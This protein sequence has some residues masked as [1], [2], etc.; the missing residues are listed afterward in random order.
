MC[1]IWG[2]K[3]AILDGEWEVDS[4]VVCPNDF[5]AGIVVC[6]ENVPIM[7]FIGLKDKNNREIYEGDII[8]GERSGL[9]CL[10]VVKYVGCSFEVDW[11]KSPYHYMDEQSRQTFGVI[12]LDM[13]MIDYWREREVIG[14]IFMNPEYLKED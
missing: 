10:G 1:D 2:M 6:D 7:E 8:K 9:K 4:I 5:S 11:I 14:N 3:W 12:D 13:R